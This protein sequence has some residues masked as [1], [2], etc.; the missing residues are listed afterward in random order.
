MLNLE[1]KFGDDPLIF[2]DFLIPK[3]TQMASTKITKRHINLWIN[4]WIYS[5]LYRSYSGPHF[6]A[7]G[8][9]TETYGVSLRIQSEC[10]KIWIRI[11]PNTD[12]FYAVTV[13]KS[14]THSRAIFNTATNMQEY[15]FSLTCIFTYKGR[16]SV[17]CPY[18]GKYGSAKT[19]FS[20]IL[21]SDIGTSQHYVKSV[22]IWGFFCMYFLTF[23]LN[24]KRYSVY[25]S[26]QSECEKIRTRKTL[27]TGPFHIVQLICIAINWL[28]PRFKTNNYKCFTYLSENQ[29]PRS[30]LSFLLLCKNICSQIST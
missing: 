9:N 20:H 6:P 1:F 12:T 30:A 10:A 13:S 11:T 23:E 8:L 14:L 3:Q 27:N 22:R 4:L 25:L 5:L 18:M 2:E 24:T 21:C 17:I 15:G 16:I 29:P 26:V 19:L 28:V 7:L